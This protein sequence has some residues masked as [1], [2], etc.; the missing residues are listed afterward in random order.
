MPWVCAFADAVPAVPLTTFTRVR[1]ILL[2]VSC[3]VSFA[4]LSPPHGFL[5]LFIVVFFY[6]PLAARACNHDTPPWQEEEAAPAVATFVGSL[7]PRN[8][9]I[10]LLEDLDWLEVSHTQLH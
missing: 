2:L 6:E 10:S 9:C 1:A 8:H 3:T 4:D 7:P 5:H